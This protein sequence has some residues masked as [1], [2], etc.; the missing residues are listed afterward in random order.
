[1]AKR[2]EVMQKSLFESKL[3]GIGIN[4]ESAK[5]LMSR[6]K[7]RQYPATLKY[8][9]YAYHIISNQINTIIWQKLV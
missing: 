4:P 8:F 6:A 3:L 9:L 7:I 5:T 2:P 1:V